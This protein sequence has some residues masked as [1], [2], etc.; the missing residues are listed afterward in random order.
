MRFG[1]VNKQTLQD[2]ELIINWW[3]GGQMWP[4]GPHLDSKISRNRNDVNSDPVSLQF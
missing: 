2:N 3:P 4:A 1:A